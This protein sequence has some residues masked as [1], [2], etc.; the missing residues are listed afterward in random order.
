MHWLESTIYFSAAPCIA[1][2][3]PLWTFKVLNFALILLPLGD[4]CGFG[5]EKYKSGYSHYI[6]HAKFNW[7]YGGSPFWDYIMGTNYKKS[8]SRKE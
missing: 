8:V 5:S 2:I 4:H 1:F 6:H 3:A 7:N